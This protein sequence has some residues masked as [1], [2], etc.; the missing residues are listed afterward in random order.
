M[1]ESLLVRNIVFA[2]KLDALW[3]DLVGFLVPWRQMA[4]LGLTDVLVLV[5]IGDHQHVIVHVELTVKQVLRLPIRLQLFPVKRI[6]DGRQAGMAH[7]EPV[8]ISQKTEIARTRRCK[9]YE[10]KIRSGD[11][12]RYRDLA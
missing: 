7:A 4:L 2:H 9:D 3:S 5:D 8:A 12:V 10:M 11:E 6:H 1:K